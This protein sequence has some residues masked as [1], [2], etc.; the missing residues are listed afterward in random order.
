[1]TDLG[2]TPAQ[3]SNAEKIIR[4]GK[5]RGMSD[6]DIQI[7]LTVALTES[8]YLNHSNSNVP[9][10]MNIPHDKVGSDHM[11]VGVFQQQVGIWGTAPELMDI[12]KSTN[13]FY[14]ALA[15]VPNRDAMSIPQAAQTV[16]RSGTPDGSN[17]LEDLPLAEKVFASLKG[18]D[19]FT[20]TLGDRSTPNPIAWVQDAGNLQRIGL[21][22][23]GASII[24]FALFQIFKDSPTLKLATGI[25]TK[26]LVK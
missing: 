10:S 14:D 12:T 4:I 6:R 9:E 13:L 11:S 22:I 18:L 1:V 7:A 16:Q 26:G 3:L 17:Y 24:I 20:S 21:F 8:D 25:A 15:K 5:S 23:I 19:V 2:M